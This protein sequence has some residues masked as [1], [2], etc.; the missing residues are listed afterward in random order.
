M[1]FSSLPLHPNLQAGIKDLGFTRPTP[2]QSDAIPPARDMMLV[3][4][5]D[6]CGLLSRVLTDEQREHMRVA[7]DKLEVRYRE[8]QE[9][10]HK[11]NDAFVEI[12]KKDRVDVLTA[13][14]QLDRVTFA[15]PHVVKSN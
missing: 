15:D 6:A 3:S 11:E 1:P 4:L 10:L 7:T 9:R 12:V 2:I 14:T 8:L 5:A 13:L